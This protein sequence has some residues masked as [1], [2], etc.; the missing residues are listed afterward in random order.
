MPDSSVTI[1]LLY[2][3]L[4]G[5]YGDGGNAV[6]LAQRLRWR[7]IEVDVIRLGAGATV[8]TSCDMYLMGGGEDGPQALAARELS[9]SGALHTAVDKGAVVFGTCAGI[10]VLGHEFANPDGTPH[11]GL[12]LLDVRTVRGTGKRAVGELLSEPLIDGLPVL[13]GYEN[14]GAITHLG[15]G[16]RP[17]GRLVHGVGNGGGDNS[18]GAVSGRILATYMHG[19]ALAR[20]PALADLLLSWTVGDLE[21]LDDADV[22]D[23]RGERLRSLR[24]SRWRRNR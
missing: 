10:Q 20:N 8:P 23:L 4:L 21:P 14:H 11:P 6:V 7:G 17:L 19:P 5:T 13:T 9:E 24:R 12:G 22:E 15:P 1:A 3:E 2:P 18:E 16:V